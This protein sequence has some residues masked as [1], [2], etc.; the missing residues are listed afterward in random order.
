MAQ[1]ILGLDIGS[2]S[3]KAALFDTAF[4]VYTLTDL[5][6]SAPLHL[7]E[8]PPEEHDIIITESIQQML[9]KQHRHQK[10]H[11]GIVREIHQQSH[12]QASASAKTIEQSSAF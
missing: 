8:A 6:Q 10:R 5:F 2:H 12:A 11:H 4:R 3:I 7:D 9:Q 1:K